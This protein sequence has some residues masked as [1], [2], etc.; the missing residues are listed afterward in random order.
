MTSIIIHYAEIGIKKGNRA[1]FERRLIHVGGDRVEAEPCRRQQLRAARRCGREDQAHPIMIAGRRLAQFERAHGRKKVSG[2]GDTLP[3]ML[4]IQNFA[5]GVLAEAIR[6][7][8]RSKAR[9]A[10]A[11]QL[12]VGAALARVT[13]VELDD[14]GVLTVTSSDPRWI[15]EI[16]RSADVIMGRLQ[17]LLGPASI[18]RLKTGAAGLTTDD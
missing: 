9:T 2:A 12:A 3:A 15:R 4:P 18:V 10:F 1:Y 6:R 11:W 7:Q 17:H 16:R 14:K 5:T 8:P 13:T